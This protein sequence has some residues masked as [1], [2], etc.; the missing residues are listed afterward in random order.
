M[1]PNQYRTA[2]EVAMT[3]Y[4]LTEEEKE[5]AT[6]LVS[7]LFT[8]DNPNGIDRISMACFHVGVS[9]GLKIAQKGN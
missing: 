2:V 7:S 1:T 4:T 8:T 6:A 9:I 3:Q 5:Q